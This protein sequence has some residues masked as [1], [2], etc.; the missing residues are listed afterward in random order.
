MKLVHGDKEPQEG[1]FILIS[2]GDNAVIINKDLK[3]EVTVN[4]AGNLDLI[5]PTDDPAYFIV[6]PRRVEAGVTEE[7]SDSL[8]DTG[9]IPLSSI[10]V[11]TRVKEYGPPPNASER[12]M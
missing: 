12:R 9:D 7:L 2:M 8:A 11:S 4:V 3:G 10:D 6:R 1:K 5:Q